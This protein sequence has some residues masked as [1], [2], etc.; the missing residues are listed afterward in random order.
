MIN[1]LHVLVEVFLTVL[2]VY[3][4]NGWVLE[5]P[6]TESYEVG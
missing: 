2:K 1:Q 6:K 5:S 4:L 3:S